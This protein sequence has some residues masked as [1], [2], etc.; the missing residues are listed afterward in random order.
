[1]EI[2]GPYKALPNEQK[3]N[4]IILLSEDVTKYNGWRKGGTIH[5]D[6]GNQPRYDRSNILLLNT[7]RP[8]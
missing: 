2:G 7:T 4:L 1:M 3:E 6:A 8:V 5:P